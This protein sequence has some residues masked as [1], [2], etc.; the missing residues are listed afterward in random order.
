MLWQEVQ[1]RE[2]GGHGEWSEGD[3]DTYDYLLYCT[4]YRFTVKS[5]CPLFVGGT[6][7]IHFD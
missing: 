5:L 3:D 2:K 1:L 4:F 6:I 7:Q